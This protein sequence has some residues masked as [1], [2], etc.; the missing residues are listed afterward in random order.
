[1]AVRHVLGGERHG[2]VG[3][4]VIGVVEDNDTLA[5]RGVAGDLDGVL[6]RFGTR[7]EQGAALLVVARGA[8]V[9]RLTHRHVLLVRADHEAGMGELG[10]LLCDGID[11]RSGG[12]ADAD[13]GD[14]GA[15]V[16][17]R[18]AIHVDQDGTLASL[19][20]DRKDRA[21]SWSDGGRP[22]GIECLRL[23]SGKLGD[24]AAHLADR[25]GGHKGERSV[26]SRWGRLVVAVASAT[27]SGRI[28]LPWSIAH[29]RLR[30]ALL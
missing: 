20:V 26:R 24:E 29:W 16:D 27:F 6:D 1:M 22:A 15:E 2:Q 10:D 13:H 21:H 7:A 3:T 5:S 18:V 12:V 9:E 30:S 17:Q 19:Y 11:H 23:R 25:G 28:H 8:G 14:A 4:A